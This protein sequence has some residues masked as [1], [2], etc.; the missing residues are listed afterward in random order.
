MQ[1]PAIYSCKVKE[2]ETNKDGHFVKSAFYS[3]HLFIYL[4][5]FRQ[6]KIRE[7]NGNEL[8]C[9]GKSIKASETP[10][11]IDHPIN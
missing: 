5:R 7:R 10:Y 4:L 11:K 6:E 2:V 1:Q 8:K 3:R 9:Q